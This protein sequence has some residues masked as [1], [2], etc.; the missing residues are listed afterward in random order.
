MGTQKL[1]VGLISAVLA[2]AIVGCSEDTQRTMP[3][4]PELSPGNA[5]ISK[6][7]DDSG[8]TIL[9]IALG[10]ANSDTPEFT[11]L[12]A[13]VL[14]ADPGIASEL[15]AKGQRTVF[16]PT[17]AAFQALFDNPDFP[18]TPEELLANA[19]LL[20]TVLLYHVSPGKRFSSDVVDSDR[21]RMKR[22]GFTFPT[23]DEKGA[24]LADNSPIT[25]DAMIIVVDIEASN[26]VIHVIDQV[27]LP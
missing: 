5:L 7:A 6:K 1:V 27:L 20:S 16:A 19:D 22:G 15:G 10:L 26:G 11:T 2:G 17:D 4:T 12:V 21:I 24:Y 3:E 23:A 9:D 25:P 18:L 13:A 8:N 14:A